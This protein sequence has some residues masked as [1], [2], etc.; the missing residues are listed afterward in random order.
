MKKLEDI[1]K[2]DL[3]QAPEGYFDLLPVIIQSRVTESA[4]KTRW[5]WYFQVSLKYA[6]PMIL[7]GVAALFYFNKPE[8]QSAEALLSSIDSLQL[9]AY[10]EDSDVTSDDLIDTVSLD[11]DEAN[12]IHEK[13]VQDIN[14][15]ENDIDDLSNEF[16]ADYF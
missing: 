3:F 16:E 12:A 8:E 4:K 7:T 2:K 15:D 1:P 13:A 5:S 6:I 14:L 11:D 10:L 9:V